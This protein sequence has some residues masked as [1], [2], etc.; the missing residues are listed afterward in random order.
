MSQ[1]EA[2][3]INNGLQDK[4]LCLQLYFKISYKD[5][6]QTL[7]SS[8]KKEHPEKSVCKRL[9]LRRSYARSSACKQKSA[10]PRAT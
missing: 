6:I 4:L 7:Q 1:T 2:C 5:I 3:N 10:A 9:A 8:H